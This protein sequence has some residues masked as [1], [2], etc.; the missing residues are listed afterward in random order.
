MTSAPLRFGLVGTGHW[1]RIA[2]APALASTEGIELAAVWGRDPGAAAALAAEHGATSFAD[3]EALL[4]AV[5]GV[6]FAVPP[7][8]QA[9]I[10]AAAARA[11]KHLMLEKPIAIAEAEA[12]E[13]VAAVAEG[14]VASV[15]F[16]ILR[17]RAEMRAWL[18]DVTARAGWAGGLTSWFGSSL[19]ESSPFNTPWRRDKGALWDL[20][21]HVISLLWGRARAGHVSDR[22]R[23]P[24]R[25]QPPDPAPPGR[26]EQHGDRVAERR[27]GGSGLRCVPVERSRPVGGA[28][29]DVRPCAAAE[30]RADR[31]RRE[32]PLRAYRASV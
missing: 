6:A 25:R 17:F 14:Q 3:I 32:H 31:T 15:V 1:A 8:V 23:G 28:A 13:L 21:P 7:D 10:A 27:R 24:G 18:A 11:G 19:L 30:H 2:H 22:R 12:D 29:Y 16:F 26:G 9:P 20:A 5:D 4:A